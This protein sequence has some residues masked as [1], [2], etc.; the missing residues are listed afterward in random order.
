MSLSF[1]FSFKGLNFDFDRLDKCSFLIITRKVFNSL[2][3]SIVRFPSHPNNRYVAMIIT[4]IIGNFTEN[5]AI[6]IKIF[7]TITISPAF[8]FS[9]LYHTPRQKA[10]PY[11]S[12]GFILTLFEFSSGA[13]P[14]TSGCLPDVRRSRGS[15]RRS[16]TPPYHARWQAAPADPRSDYTPPALCS[17]A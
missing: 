7:L 3:A 1:S 16:R 9:S 4:S 8:Q 17:C 6:A 2:E 5:S 12:R 11:R 14:R 13:F 15:A 10:S